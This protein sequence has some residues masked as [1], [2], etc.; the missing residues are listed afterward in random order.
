VRRTVLPD[1]AHPVLI[2]D[3]NAV[4]TGALAVELFQAQAGMGKV[5]Q[6]GGEL[7]PLKRLA[8]RL[9]FSMAWNFL[10]GIRSANWR[11]GSSR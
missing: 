7:E 4:L 2:I 1:E 9:L 8:G 6:L 11:V 10:T 3:S 5:A